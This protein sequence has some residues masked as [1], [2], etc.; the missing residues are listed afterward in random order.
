MAAT[1]SDQA[2]HLQVWNAAFEYARNHPDGPDIRHFIARRFKLTVQEIGEWVDSGYKHGVRSYNLDLAPASARFSPALL[3][4]GSSD[5]SAF[6]TYRITGTDSNGD[7]VGTTRTFE[8]K[9][10]KT[11][12]MT[13]GDALQQIVLEEQSLIKYWKERHGRDVVRINAE[14][15]Q[16]VTWVCLP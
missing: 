9:F 6:V 16:S 1:S 10:Q 8:V 14:Q 2:I 15:A 7:T 11:V 13:R 12:G 3:G 5:R 4:C